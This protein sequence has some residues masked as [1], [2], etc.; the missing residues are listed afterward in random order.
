MKTKFLKNILSATIIAVFSL[1]GSI[2]SAN[3]ISILN[4]DGGDPT[5]SI[6]DGLMNGDTF[7]VNIQVDIDEDAGSSGA[8]VSWGSGVLTLDSIVFGAGFF[9]FGSTMLPADSPANLLA[10]G[11][12]GIDN[13]GAPFNWVTLGFTYNGGS[14][15][16]SVIPTSSVLGGWTEKVTANV[17]NFDTVN[18]ATINPAI[19]PLPP[20]IWL[21][22]SALIGIGA[23]RNRKIR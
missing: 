3:T 23:I 19:V 12:F 1:C 10:L 5:P 13:S 16:L 8:D 22:G 6:I 21:F 11:A 18:N 15:A 14:T 17:I 9:D 2:A 7:S 4:A 20:A